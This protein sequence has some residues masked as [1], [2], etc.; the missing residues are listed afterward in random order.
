[1]RK[2]YGDKKFPKDIYGRIDGS[3]SGLNNGSRFLGRLRI[4]DSKTH[5]L[6]PGGHTTSMEGRFSTDGKGVLFYKSSQGS[7][8]KA[9]FY[10]MKFTPFNPAYS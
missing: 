10:D 8:R 6:K 3:F 7:G 2:I 1:M 9:V 4:E 5:L